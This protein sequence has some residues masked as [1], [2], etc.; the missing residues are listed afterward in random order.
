K[1]IGNF[2]TPILGINTGRFGFLTEITPDELPEHISD[3]LE[4]RYFVEKRIMLEA[5]VEG[6]E[7]QEL[8]AVNDFVIDKGEYPRIVKIA[9]SI[10]NEFFHTYTSNGII[11]STATGSTAYSLSAGG[12]IIYPTVDNLLITPICPHTLSVRPIIIPGDFSVCL[13][14]VSGPEEIPLNADGQQGIIINVGQKIT[15]KRSNAVVNLV[16]FSL[17]NF[18]RVLSNKLGWGSR[19]ENDTR[20]R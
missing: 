11:V 15:I 9:L 18:F 13:E 17:H 1:S 16:H 6:D 4:K 3:L 10:N 7:T 8:L 5:S 2:T 12:P 20:K 14:L 19:R